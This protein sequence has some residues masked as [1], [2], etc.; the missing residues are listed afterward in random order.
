MAD[1]NFKVEL[2]I[3]AP[4]EEYVEKM[5]ER[6]PHADR[7]WDSE[8]I[9]PDKPRLE[10][11]IRYEEDWNGRGEYFVFE[12]KWTNEEYWGLDCAFACI[13]FKDGEMVIGKGDLLNYQALTKVRELMRLGIR[14][15]FA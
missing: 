7:I 6:M 15:Y 10:A 8:I 14:F 1:K 4:S 2:E 5:L 9:D 3:E 12:N 11:R 13:S